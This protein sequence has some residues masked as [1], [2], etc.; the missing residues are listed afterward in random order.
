MTLIELSEQE[1]KNLVNGKEIDKT[2]FCY[3]APLIIRK[4]KKEIIFCLY[5]STPTKNKEF[6]KGDCR[7]SFN[8]ANK[9]SNFRTPKRSYRGLRA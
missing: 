2:I 4:T 8:T 7:K 5:C 9:E 1:I 6:C 3:S